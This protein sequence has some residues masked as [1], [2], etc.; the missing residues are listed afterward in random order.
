MNPILFAIL[1]TGLL[2]NAGCSGSR[3]ISAQ[4]FNDNNAPV[5]VEEPGRPVSG[6]QAYSH[7]FAIGQ[8]QLAAVLGGIRYNPS[9][10]LAA[11]S[12]QA[13]FSQKETVGLAPLLAASLAEADSR[14]RV[15]FVSYNRG[16]AL[17]L[18]TRRKTEG[19]IFVDPQERLNIAF[20]LINEVL[21][22]EEHDDPATPHPVDPRQITHS[23]Q[24]LVP[25]PWYRLG[26]IAGSQDPIPMWAI[27]DLERVPAAVE[28]RQASP[29]PPANDSSLENADSTPASSNRVP[30]MTNHPSADEDPRFFREKLKD[31]IRLLKELYEEKLITEE[32]Y[33]RKR[34]ELLD[35]IR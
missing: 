5:F 4:V 32:E 23:M 17:L 1:M 31:D 6:T 22:V 8:S 7:P 12:D 2:F 21:D 24:P 16:P 15:R 33:G 14:Q 34:Q 25:R 30:A 35:K 9:K 26:T 10:L 27:V 19:I 28:K 29:V 11:D 3:W 18:P 20:S 13:V